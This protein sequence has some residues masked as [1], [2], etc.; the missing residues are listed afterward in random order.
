MAPGKPGQ[1]VNTLSYEEACDLMAEAKTYE[2][3]NFQVYAK[4]DQVEEVFGNV[5]RREYDDCPGHKS[6][7]VLEADLEVYICVNHKIP[8]Y[9][10]GNVSGQSFAD[11]WH[12]SRRRKILKELNVHGCTPRC[13]QDPL[14]RIVHEIRVGRRVAPQN[15]PER[16]PGMHTNFL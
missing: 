10:F 12:G 11:V 13:R 1:M 4:F 8:E 3:E 2:D 9:S 15:L 16:A 5:D 7:A 6:T 14:N